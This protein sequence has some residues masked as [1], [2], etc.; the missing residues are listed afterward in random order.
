MGSEIASAVVPP[1]KVS[2][3]GT[4]DIERIDVIKD[5]RIIY[6]HSPQTPRRTVEFSY[7]DLQV[8]PGSHYYYARVIQKDRNMAWV[9]PIWVDVP[10]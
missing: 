3:A 9:T 5:N 6:S 10:G 7:Q 4:A 1:L 2:I 8:T